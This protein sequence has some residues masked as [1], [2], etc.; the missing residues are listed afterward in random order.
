MRLC[1]CTCTRAET[2]G[3]VS[4]AEN[5][6]SSLQL[7]YRCGTVYVLE[8]RAELHN[9]LTYSLHNHSDPVV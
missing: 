5:Q 2:V 3:V 8:V 6:N 4:H 7:R 9:I 1:V